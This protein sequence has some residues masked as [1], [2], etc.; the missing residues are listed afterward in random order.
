MA[1]G[2]TSKGDVV[3]AASSCLGAL[4]SIFVPFS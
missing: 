4:F 2:F 1:F 3:D